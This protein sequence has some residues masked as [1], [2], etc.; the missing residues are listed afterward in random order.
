MWVNN[1][2]IAVISIR[3]T[4]KSD[5]SWLENF[6]AAMVPA[7]GK[8]HLGDSEDFAYN[9]ASNPKAGVHVGWLLGL[10]DLSKTILPKLYWLYQSKGIK[11]YI[12]V[13]HSQGAAIACLLALL[14]W[15]PAKQTV[16]GR[17]I[18]FKTYCSAPPKPGNVYY[19]YDFNY[20]TRNGWCISVI[21][22]ADWVPQTPFSIQTINDFNTP[23]PFVNFNDEIKN[24][25]FFKRL[26]IKHIFN[27]LK[28]T[29]ENAQQANQEYLGKLAYTFV[30]KQLPKFKEPDVH[31]G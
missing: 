20:L 2:G 13:G 7:S 12:I 1:K 4:T 11:N 19:S 5:A 14:P 8:L 24:Q 10:A 21:N 6:Y 31:E 26:Y 23:N 18:T 9:L 29:P 27:K 15:R 22:S 28:K 3:G 30:Q 16:A 17:D 25:P